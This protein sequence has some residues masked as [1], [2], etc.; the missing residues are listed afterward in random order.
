MNASHTWIAV[1]GAALTMIVAPSAA[2]ADKPD[3][4][5]QQ[6]GT[7]GPGP[8]SVPLDAV[9]RA[10][11]TAA[12][13]SLTSPDTRDAIAGIYPNVPSVTVAS[14]EPGL[15]WRDAGLGAA[16]GAMAIVAML[17]SWVVVGRRRTASLVQH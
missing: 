3:A 6:F 8:Q 9:D 1:L 13:F 2:A 11:S 17:A 5:H 12:P 10:A 14:A 7:Y 16:A 4:E 15:D